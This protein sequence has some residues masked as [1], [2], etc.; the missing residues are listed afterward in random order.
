M[1][2]KRDYYQILGVERTATEDEI[3]AA[4]RKLAR[5]LHPDV[6]KAPDAQARFTEI[7]EAYDVLSDKEKRRAYDRF[8]HA[9]PAGA[10]GRPGG[11]A[12]RGGVH[13]QWQSGG[14]SGP[15]GFDFDAD[16]LGSMFDT[17]FGGAARGARGA[18]RA[19]HGR[20]ARPVAGQDVTH[21][22]RLDFESAAR[23]G[24]RRISLLRGGDERSIEV[25]I[26]PAVRDGAKLRIR[27]EGHPSPTPGGAPGDLILTIRVEPHPVL[28]RGRPGDPPD[29]L[30]LSLEL[31]LTI[32][33]ATLGC[34]V[35]VPT[36]DGPVDLNVPP[37]AASGKYLRLRERGL[38][39]A[40]GRRGDLYAR[41]RV[42]PPDGSGLAP[43]EAE[44]LRRI[45]ERTPALRTG[46]GWPTSRGAAA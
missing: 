13:Y 16:D 45:A 37:G 36:L 9:G 28:V 32:A 19:Q 43:G 3:R 39:N 12:G 5:K 21:T 33:E 7:Q 27:G 20:R 4:Y 6:N 44:T 24:K 42:V 30:D 10:A 29:S 23:G 22:M 26:P 18:G 31:P 17:F 2:A 41:V 40:A 46:P 35:Q 38:E 11:G 34:R 15:A 8:G 25:T 1:S 14:G